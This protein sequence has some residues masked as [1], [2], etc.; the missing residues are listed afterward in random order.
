MDADDPR[1]L[2]VRK[3]GSKID[4]DDDQITI[5]KTLNGQRTASS[6]RINEKNS[7]SGGRIRGTSNGSDDND[8][9]RRSQQRYF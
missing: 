8:D 9:A 5:Q 3:S 7:K 1:R 4:V 2:M 6:G